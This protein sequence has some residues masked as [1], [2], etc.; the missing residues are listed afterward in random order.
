MLFHVSIEVDDPQHVATVVAELFGGEALP[1][2][3]VTP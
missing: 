2:P 3:P 1:F